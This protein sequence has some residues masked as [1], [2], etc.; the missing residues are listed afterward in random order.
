MA[1][2]EAG[3]Y[4]EIAL[5]IFSPDMEPVTNYIIENI[6]GGLLLEDEDEDSR[7]T[8]KF[9]IAAQE[10]TE[11]LLSGLSHF[12]ANINPN[13][14]DIRLRSK[15]IREL[16]WIEAYQK[17]VT[18]M[19]VGDSIVVKPPWDTKAYPDRMEILIE[20]KMAFGTGRHES[21]RGSL[22]LMEQI[23]LAGR[24]ILDLGCGSGILGIYAAKRGAA[25]VL[26]Y[27]IDPL[28]IENSIENYEIND[29]AANCHASLGSLDDIPADLRFDIIVVNIIKAVIVPIV[30]RLNNRLPSGGTLILAG[31][32]EN[33][34]EDIETALKAAGLNSFEIRHDNGW[35]AYLVKKP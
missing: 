15:K 13:Y 34:R 30:G 3:Y 23:E 11:S 35:V 29:V 7:T 19:E 24:T 22:A 26:G 18:P 8:I 12:L 16:D 10:D 2:D 32:L 25:K 9:Y 14:R 6:C 28:A 17:S 33:D 31:L 21:T 4:H 20:P 27:D 5:T 1:Q